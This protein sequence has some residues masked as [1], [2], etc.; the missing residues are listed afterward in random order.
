MDTTLKLA[1]VSLT[2]EGVQ[3]L[4][5]NAN[6]SGPSSLFFIIALYAVLWCSTVTAEITHSGGRGRVWGG[7]GHVTELEIMW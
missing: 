2:N 5:V 7:Q 3:S 6:V 1:F 4:Q